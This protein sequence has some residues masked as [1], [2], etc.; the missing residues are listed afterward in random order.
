MLLDHPD[1]GGRFAPGT[2]G[3]GEA[4]REG[5][6]DLFGAAGRLR[7]VADPQLVV[8]SLI[9]IERIAG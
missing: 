1:R 9:D 5:P 7:R 3:R 8:P 4:A 6:G 2:G